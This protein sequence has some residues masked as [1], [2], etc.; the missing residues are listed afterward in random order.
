[1]SQ[2]WQSFGTSQVGLTGNTSSPKFSIFLVHNSISNMITKVILLVVIYIFE[3]NDLGGF[4]K[5]ALCETLM[6][7][8][9]VNGLKLPSLFI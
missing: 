3:Y 9:Q 6:T 7:H 8:L 5:S 4:L 1:M 2:N